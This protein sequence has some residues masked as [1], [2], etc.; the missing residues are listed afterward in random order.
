MSTWGMK[1][2]R[3]T[4]K[5][6]IDE[7]ATTEF[8]RIRYHR[9]VLMIHA[10]GTSRL[11]HWR[12]GNLE[13]LPSKSH[14]SW[15][16]G[17]FWRRSITALEQAVRQRWEERQRLWWEAVRVPG[18]CPAQLEVDVKMSHARWC[19]QR[20]RQ[21]NNHDQLLAYARYCAML[22]TGIREWPSHSCY[23]LGI[24]VLPIS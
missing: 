4:N 7:R 13:C 14:P 2:G 15:N 11:S 12:M 21:S 10:E 16:R 18:H 19:Q 8:N 24:T 1:G 22:F 3:Q 17:Y 5:R 20:L 6:C 23:T 9:D